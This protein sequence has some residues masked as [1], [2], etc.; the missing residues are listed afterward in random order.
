MFQ[1]KKV[2]KPEVGVVYQ[3]TKLMVSTP[4]FTPGRKN[5]QNGPVSDLQLLSPKQVRT[6][7]PTVLARAAISS[8]LPK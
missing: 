5:L 7:A 8:S 4:G 2:Q 3:V 1:K 6:R